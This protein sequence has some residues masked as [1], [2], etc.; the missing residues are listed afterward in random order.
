MRNLNLF[1]YLGAFVTIVLA[2]AVS[3][4]MMSV[5]RLILARQRVKWHL[6]PI[7]AAVYVF[8][9]VLSEF[10]SLWVNANVHAVPFLYLV[11]LVVVSGFAALAAFTVLPDH[12]PESGLDLLAYY[13][14]N[15]HYLYTTLALGFVGDVAR[16]VYLSYLTTGHFSVGDPQFLVYL[17]L[18]VVTVA[19]YALLGWSADRRVHAA[20]LALIYG[21]VL[22]NFA[23]WQV[24]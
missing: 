20:G 5:H 19:M 1:Q 7:A 4:L 12:V 2:L 3:D 8:L 24:A 18:T 21:W 10:F 22:Y 6:L 15:R 16:Q 14:D 11:L 13:L 23:G 9:A 17:A